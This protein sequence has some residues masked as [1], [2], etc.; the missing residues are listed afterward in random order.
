ML[1]RI[2]LVLVSY[3]KRYGQVYFGLHVMLPDTR[4]RTRTGISL[5]FI[6]TTV[7]GGCKISSQNMTIVFSI[8]QEHPEIQRNQY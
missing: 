4:R 3:G 5:G 7:V 1:D 8:D 2:K 6:L